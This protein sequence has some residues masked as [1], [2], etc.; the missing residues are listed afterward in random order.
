MKEMTKPQGQKEGA[1]NAELSKNQYTINSIQF[2]IDQVPTK[3]SA[4]PRGC[5]DDKAWSLL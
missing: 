2:S 5:E 3:C 4:S 1:A